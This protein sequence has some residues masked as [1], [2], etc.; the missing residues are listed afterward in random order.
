MPE[1]ITVEMNTIEFEAAMQRLRQGVREGIIDPKQGTLPVQARLLAEKA[2]S[3]TPPLRHHGLTPLK[4]GEAATR[5]DISAVFKP[6]SPSTFRSKRLQA[7][8][9][10]DDREAWRVISPKFKKHG[11]RNTQAIGFTEGWHRANRISRGR[12]SQ[13]RLRVVTL[14]PQGEAARRYADRVVKRVGWARSGW[15]A[16]ILAFGGKVKGS[17]VAR[18]GSQGGAA[19]DGTASPESPFIKVSNKTSWAKYNGGEANRILRN[20]FQSRIK[21]IASYADRLMR[22]A[23]AK[24]ENGALRK[25]A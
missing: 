11:I 14:G 25:A 24:A 8:V 2:Q 18:H 3:F 6:I 1:G 13:R 21:A 12:I 16:G 10:D 19:Y 22:L 9:R 15:N 5:R 17:W 7:I 20:A 23:A 4:A